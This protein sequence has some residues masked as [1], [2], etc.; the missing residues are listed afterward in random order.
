M[1]TTSVSSRDKVADTAQKLVNKC[2]QGD[3]MWPIKNLYA[4]DIVSTESVRNENGQIQIR[5]RDKI[6]KKNEEWFSHMQIHE[7]TISEPLISDHEFAVMFETDATCRKTN[8]RICLRELAV[9]QVND[10][11]K[12]ERETFFYKDPI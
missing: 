3:Y 7:N 2:R 8:K 9:Y 6:I 11:G 1:T 5:G 10:N 12:I 4:D